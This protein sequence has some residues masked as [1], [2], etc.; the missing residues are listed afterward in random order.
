MKILFQLLT[1]LLICLCGDA[2]AAV[3]PISFP[4]SVISMILLFVLFLFGVLRPKH[5]RETS[6]FLLENMALFFI[7]AGVGILRYA[8]VL[9]DS[10]GAI[11]LICFITTPIV[12]AVTGWTVQLAMRLMQKKEGK[13]HD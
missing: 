7:P 13:Q 9:K 5:I 2:I 1:L 10:L 4:S 11:V 12:Y 8:S 3:L 6:D